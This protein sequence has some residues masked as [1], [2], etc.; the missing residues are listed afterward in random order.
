MSDKWFGLEGWEHLL[1][2]IDD[3]VESVVDHRELG[4]E[5]ETVAVLEFAPKKVKLSA[6][7]ILETVYDHLY[8]G[9]ERSRALLRAWGDPPRVRKIAGKLP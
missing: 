3:V 4:A 8:E 5:P 9:S 6:D 1:S 2:E 7:D